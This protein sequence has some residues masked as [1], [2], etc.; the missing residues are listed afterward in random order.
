MEA[1]RLLGLVRTEGTRA[2]L[3]VWTQDLAPSD[4][5]GL[6]WN[7]CLACIPKA[8]AALR[9]FWS[10]SGHWP[11]IIP[12]LRSIASR[13]IPTRPRILLEWS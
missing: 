12:I 10:C 11:L 8:H 13:I 9:V 7:L 3:V 4:T 6:F 5:G 2:D 1:W